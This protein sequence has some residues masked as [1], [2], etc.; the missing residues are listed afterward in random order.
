MG[1]AQPIG[2]HMV[3]GLRVQAALKR[4][5]HDFFAACQ[6]HPLQ[7]VV[8]PERLL[9]KMTQ[10]SSLAQRA[11]RV[12][13]MSGSRVGVAVDG[14]AVVE[15]ALVAV[16]EGAAVALGAGVAGV[17]VLGVAVL[18]VAA[19]GV[20]ALGAASR[21]AAEAGASTGASVLRA[22]GAVSQAAKVRERRTGAIGA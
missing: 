12:G 21:A 11:S 16:T 22:V 18:G 7:Q 5:S 15:G 10:S 6:V 19:V 4:V 17:A 1:M 13:T 14:T 20:A 2:G 3:G 9:S 8:G